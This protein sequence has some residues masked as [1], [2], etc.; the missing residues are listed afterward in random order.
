[1]KKSFGASAIHLGDE[2]GFAP[3][4][5]KNVEE[6]LEWMQKAVDEAG[7]AAE[8]RFALDPASSEFFGKSVGKYRLGEKTY[9]SA[10]LVDYYKNLVS[11]YKIVSI[12]DGMSEEDWSGWQLMNKELG[13]KIQIVGDDVLVTNVERIKKAIAQDA[14][15][16]LLLKVNQIGT[17]SESIDAANLSFKNNW[18]VVVSHRSGETEDSFIADLVVGLSAGQSKF[19]GPARSERTCKYN[20]LL[21]IEEALGS[22]A[23]YGGRIIKFG[24]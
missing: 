1:L 17:L 9:S 6:R 13:H 18:N 21:R 7:Y 14:C 19:G 4:Q 8:L 11:Q 3:T 5:L 2:G 16:A 10:E 15:N 22:K 12:E 24:R 23:V 20:Q